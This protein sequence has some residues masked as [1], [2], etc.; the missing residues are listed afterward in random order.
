MWHNNS[1]SQRTE[2]NRKN[3]EGEGWRWQGQGSGWGGGG[4]VEKVLKREERQYSGVLI[5]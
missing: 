3:S 1:F 2:D 4:R 5:K